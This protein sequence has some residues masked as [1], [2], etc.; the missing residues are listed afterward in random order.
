MVSGEAD[1]R[2]DMSM[3]TES[4]NLQTPVM[5]IV[6]HRNLLFL[7]TLAILFDTVSTI[8]FM[9]RVGIELEIHPLVRLGSLIYGPVAGPL[10]FAFLFK[11]LAGLM[12]LFYIRRLAPSILRLAAAISAFA[13]V[14]NLW[15]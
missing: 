1:N 4:D 14:L 12:I 6:R 10:L 13:G 7:Y 8:H 2:E 15:V 11:L 9:T 3:N 5:M